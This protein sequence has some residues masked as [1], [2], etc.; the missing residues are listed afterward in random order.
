[1]IR[2]TVAAALFTL[3]PALVAAQSP[4]AAELDK[5]AAQVDAKVLAW[6]RDIH[7]HP[8]LGN[9]ETRTAKLVAD[10]LRSLGLEV[11]TGVA[12]TGVI[13]V[14]RGGRPGPVIAL[15]ADMDAL[16]V[17][18]LVNLPFASKVRTEYNGQQV[19]VMHACGHDTHVAILMGTAELLA[20]MKAQLPGTIVFIFQPAE[21]GAPTGERG[22]AELMLEEGAFRDPKPE[23]VFGLHVMSALPSGHLGY[24]PNG[25]FAA[26][27][28]LRIVVRGK[29]THAAMPWLGV[30]PVVT[31][32]QIVLGLQTVVSQQLDLRQAPAVV[33]VAVINGGVRNNIIPDS[34]VMLGTIRT[35]EPGMQKE[36]HMR[37]KRIA[38]QIAA[39]A[40]AEASVEITVGLPVTM[41]DPALTEW[42]SKTMLRVAGPGKAYV[43]PVQLGAEDFS[44]FA[45]TVPGFFFILGGV[46]DGMTPQTAPSNH[47]P[48]FQVDEKSLPVG[49]RAMSQL[50]VDYLYRK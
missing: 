15:R 47:S 12:H 42:A 14:L 27:D 41:N 20:G 28:P 4:L 25:T 19:G 24:R 49:L 16:P 7:E 48:Y 37:V 2:K 36:V 34:V 13:G 50:A 5:R 32:A 26:S 39:S 17:T 44:Y 46:P 10:H 8:E 31:A 1:M 11:R 23:A 18:E 9:R 43:T 29:Q 45:N 6:R 33:T 40:G 22:G 38:E 21:E 35:L 3:V 30:D